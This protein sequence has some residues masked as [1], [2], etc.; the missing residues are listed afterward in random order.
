[1][2]TQ[3]CGGALDTTQTRIRTDAGPCC[4]IFQGN[5]GSKG[6]PILF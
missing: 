4:Y 5:E 6:L 1:M 3:V 2:S